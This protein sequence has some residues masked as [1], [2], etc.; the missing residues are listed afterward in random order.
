MWGKCRRLFKER[1]VGLSDWAG[2]GLLGMVGGL[3]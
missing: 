3:C 2:L 1:K